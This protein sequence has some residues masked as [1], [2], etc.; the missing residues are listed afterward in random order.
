MPI[1]EWKSQILA[2]LKDNA[3]VTP[4]QLAQAYGLNINT[5]KT[6]L[7]R[8]AKEGTI[9]KTGHGKYEITEED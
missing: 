9:K 6:N 8:L 4:M 3:S 5:A 1:P 7:T 2:F